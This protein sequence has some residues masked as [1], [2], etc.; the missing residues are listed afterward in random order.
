MGLMGLGAQLW[1]L[2]TPQENLRKGVRAPGG[3]ALP[4]GSAPDPGTE[5]KA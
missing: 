5:E 4:D 2:K 3:T 1:R